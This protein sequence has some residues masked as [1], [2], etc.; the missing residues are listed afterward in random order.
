M[1]AFGVSRLSVS[2]L[3]YVVDWFAFRASWVSTYDVVAVGTSRLSVSVC[4]YMLG[5]Q[6][7][8][9]HVM[10]PCVVMFPYWLI[11]AFVVSRLGISVSLMPV[12]IPELTFR[13]WST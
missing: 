11:V 7:T 4:V 6:K 8:P 9:R 10:V 1:S 2:V 5:A 3:V 13:T 12:I